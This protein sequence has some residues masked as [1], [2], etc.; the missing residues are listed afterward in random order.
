MVTINFYIFRTG[1]LK[2]FQDLSVL[3]NIKKLQIHIYLYFYYYPQR[4]KSTCRSTT[5]L[6]TRDSL[7]GPEFSTTAVKDL[8]CNIFT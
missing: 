3:L 7:E 6:F 8:I 4:K 5:N 1:D 2:D